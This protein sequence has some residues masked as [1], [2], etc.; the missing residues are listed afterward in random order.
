[1]I[2]RSDLYCALACF[3]SNAVTVFEK[4]NTLIQTEIQRVHRLKCDLQSLFYEL[5]IRFIKA[6]VIKASDSVFY[7]QYENT[8][9]HKSK[10][11]I[12]IS[13]LTK[14]I[15][16]K[17]SSNEVELLKSSKKYSKKL[18]NYFLQIYYI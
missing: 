11:E 18:F 8:L 6:D 10:A 2:L 14:E 17:L 1:M 16:K 9:N 13:S 5:L 4:Y 12:T 7:A 15:L 3:L